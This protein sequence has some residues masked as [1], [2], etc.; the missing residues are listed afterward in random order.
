MV[1]F[2][3]AEHFEG[4]WTRRTSSQLSSGSV[5]HYLHS[6]GKVITSLAKWRVSTPFSSRIPRAKPEIEVSLKVYWWPRLRGGTGI[7]HLALVISLLC[8]LETDPFAFHRYRPQ[9]VLPS[10]CF[11]VGIDAGTVC[12]RSQASSESES[13]PYQGVIQGLCMAREGGPGNFQNVPT[14]LNSWTRSNGNRTLT[15]SAVMSAH[16]C[17]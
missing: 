7:E 11:T 14:T 10:K 8:T 15:V 3:S 4:L 16:V 12:N 17:H 5:N 9:I 6:G 13:S 2:E 1:S